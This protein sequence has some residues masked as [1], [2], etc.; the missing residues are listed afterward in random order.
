MRILYL[1]T[2]DWYF[3]SHRLALARAARA[4]GAR[5]TVVTAPG[6]RVAEIEA[7]G[8]RHRPLTFH[9]T[10]R[11]QPR[12]ALVLRVLAR[13]YREEA[14]DLV[15]H[16]SFLPIFY[17]SLAA[18]SA[19]V[20]AIVNAVTGLGHAFVGDSLGRR[21]LRWAVERAYKLALGHG[22]QTVLFQN[23]EDLT[24]FLARGLVRREICEV[25][26]GSGVDLGLFAPDPSPAPNGD[27]VPQILHASRM[28]WT[29]GVA[30][31]VAA[32]RL[33]R[34]RGVEHRL[35]LAGRTHPA[36]PESIPEEQLRA[37]QREGVATWLG[38][39]EDLGRV[40]EESAV[41]CLPSAYREG[42]PLVL[43]E[44]CAAGRPIVTTD[45]PGCREAVADGENGL[46]VPVH[47]PERLAAALAALLEQ[48]ELR[49]R[50]G[51]AGRER[52]LAHF[53][54]EL[55]VERTLTTYRSLLGDVRRQS[56]SSSFAAEGGRDDHD[57]D[58]GGGK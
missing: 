22:N 33:L 9:R 46:L 42:I 10:K 30:D 57:E 47:A 27:P 54:S 49:E 48:P 52:A 53:S 19:G 21:V 37:W 3:L 35:V 1:V 6:E 56:L 58:E 32:S 20:P 43:L 41:V 23:E 18:R 31:T 45:V 8:F 15:H 7:D 40:L 12:N 50:M 51:R 17:G 36:N 34:A 38:H 29:K 39:C 24:H 16:V 5:V 55:V 25:V 2:D 14:P 4:A 44:A 11:A 13:L 28:L 26:P